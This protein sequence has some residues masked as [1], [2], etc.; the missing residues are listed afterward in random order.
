MYCCWTIVASFV[1]FSS[2][3]ALAFGFSFAPGVFIVLRWPLKFSQ[4]Q[5]CIC[6]LHLARENPSLLALRSWQ[7][8]LYPQ[9]LN[10]TLFWVNCCACSRILIGFLQSVKFNS[11]WFQSWIASLFLSMA[12]G[13]KNCFLCSGHLIVLGWKS[14]LKN[15]L[16]VV[17]L[18]QY[19]GILPGHCPY[20]FHFTDAGCRMNLVCLILPSSV[21]L[22]SWCVLFGWA[23]NENTKLSLLCSAFTLSGQN[24]GFN[25]TWNINTLLVCT[26]VF[27]PVSLGVA[28]CVTSQAWCSMHTRASHWKTNIN[29]C[30]YF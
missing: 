21:K 13:L 14:S 8:P 19:C 16:S 4:T 7:I 3:Q 27:A 20:S 6:C 18:Q 17:G 2:C 28:V 29:Q 9:I 30:I 15:G 23:G 1:P 26:A 24:S 10:I 25:V 22:C 12:S 11:A 5:L